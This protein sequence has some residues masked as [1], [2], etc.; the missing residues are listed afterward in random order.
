MSEYLTYLQQGVNNIVFNF[1]YIFSTIVIIYLL[2]KTVFQSRNINFSFSRIGEMFNKKYFIYCILF[3]TGFLVNKHI[4]KILK[5]YFKASRPTSKNSELNSKNPEKYGFPS[6]HAQ[7][8]FFAISF[9]L[10]VVAYSDS[11]NIKLFF[12]ISF[13]FGGATCFQRW[14]TGMHTIQQL[15]GGAF[16]GSFIG[17][18]FA[19]V[20]NLISNKI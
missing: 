8:L 2:Y 12:L 1:P 5:L 18:S 9:L 4:N 19:G 6:G 17:I 20:G 16:F 14:I 7:I 13:F 15:L 3:I 11:K 10:Y